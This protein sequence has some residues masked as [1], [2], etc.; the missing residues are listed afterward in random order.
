[1]I[2][3]SHDLIRTLDYISPQSLLKA[4]T[5]PAMASSIVEI[6]DPKAAT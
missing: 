6:A 2:V 5:F 4:A 1:M 3:M